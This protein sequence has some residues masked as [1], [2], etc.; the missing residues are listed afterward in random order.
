MIF[1]S[2]MCLCTSLNCLS[3]FFKFIAQRL[4]TQPTSCQ[5]VSFVM[6]TTA[7]LWFFAMSQRIKAHTSALYIK[8]RELNSVSKTVRSPPMAKSLLIFKVAPELDGG[9][10]NRTSERQTAH[11]SCQGSTFFFLAYKHFSKYYEL[12]VNLQSSEEL[13][14]DKFLQCFCYFYE[15]V[16]LGR[17]SLPHPRLCTQYLTRSS[18]SKQI[19]K[20]KEEEMKEKEQRRKEG[21]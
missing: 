9:D 16:D 5:S 14:F 3:T 6:A 18:S 7:K 11:Y 12:L 21:E 19:C 20:K 1:V 10:G 4:S 2:K 8:R 13:D 17:S 15:G